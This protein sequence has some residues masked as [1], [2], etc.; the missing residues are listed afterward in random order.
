MD[1]KAKQY[2]DAIPQEKK[3]LYQQL[4]RAILELYPVGPP[5]VHLVFQVLLGL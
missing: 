2:I 4:E 1:E 5:F 3:A